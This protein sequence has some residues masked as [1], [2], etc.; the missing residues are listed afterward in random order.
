[1]RL[2]SFVIAAAATATTCGTYSWQNFS[3]T[4]KVAPQYMAEPKTA[5]ELVEAV[6][7]AGQNGKRIRMTGSGH[8]HS[9]VAVTDEV[10]LTPKGLVHPL[11]LDRTRLKKPNAFGLVR[12]ESGITLRALN[13]YLDTQNLAM[14]NMGGYDGQTIVGAAVT[15]THGSGLDYGPIAAQIVSLQVVGEGGKMYQVEPSDGITKPQGFPGKLENDPSIPVTLIQNDDV[16]NAMIVS[17]G[18]MGIVYSVVLQ[19]DP[20]FWLDEHRTL[21]K[22]SEVAKPDGVLDRIMS[23]RPVDDSAHPAEHYELQYNPYPVDGER[24]FLLTTRTRYYEKPQNGDTT[25]GQP[26]TDALQGFV[27][28]SSGAIAFIA[29]TAPATVPGL[30]EQA[31]QAQVDDNGY[32]SDS[33][34]VFNIGKVNDTKAI[35]VEIGFDLADTRDVLLR[36]FEISEELQKRGLVHSAPA[37]VRFVDSTNAMIG[38]SQGRLTGVLELIVLTEVNGHEELLRTYE[39]TLMEEFGGRLHWGLDLSVMQGPT[40]PSQLYERWDDWLAM[41]RQFNKGTFDGKVTDRLGIS[42]RP[43]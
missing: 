27:V 21:L 3:G 35:A 32:V 2:L 1:M 5:A 25:R 41:Y 34:N 42:V 40:W 10:L 31:L 23:G 6:T 9:D 13:T 8:S 29:N 12:V 11:S 38:M 28:I 36:A 20:K 43:R 24:S 16:F 39:Q 26:L 15:G 22:W 4:Q 7:L 14:Q 30:I 18:S 19:A 37:S 17:I 33:Y